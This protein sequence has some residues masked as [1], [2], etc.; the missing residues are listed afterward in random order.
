MAQT[1]FHV[2]VTSALAQA[3]D[4]LNAECSLEDK[5]TRLSALMHLEEMILYQDKSQVTAE[6]SVFLPRLAALPVD[7]SNSSDIM[8]KTFLWQ[9]VTH[10]V[11]LNELLKLSEELFLS[12]ISM[13][14]EMAFNKNTPWLFREGLLPCLL[15]MEPHYPGILVV[16]LPRLFRVIVSEKS[17][18]IQ[19]YVQLFGTILN[20]SFSLSYDIV[21]DDLKQEIAAYQK[22]MNSIETGPYKPSFKYVVT[23][24]ILR[25]KQSKVAPVCQ[26]FGYSQLLKEKIRL[27]SPVANVFIRQQLQGIALGS[28]GL[29]NNILYLFTYCQAVPDKVDAI[30]CL[31]NSDF[32]SPSFKHV[33]LSWYTSRIMKNLDTQGVSLAAIRSPFC[34]ST[35]VAFKQ[36]SCSVLDSAILSSFKTFGI[37]NYDS[38]CAILRSI[39]LKNDTYHSQYCELFISQLFRCN[40]RSNSVNTIVCEALDAFNDQLLV[41]TFAEQLDTF[42]LST[43]SKKRQRTEK[44]LG[45][46]LPIFSK[47]TLRRL[48][49]N[50]LFLWE[51][52][53]IITGEEKQRKQ[54]TEE[55]IRNF[56]FFLC[57]FICMVPSFV[58][59]NELTSVNNGKII[60]NI[61]EIETEIGSMA[62][63]LIQYCDKFSATPCMNQ[64]LIV[65]IYKPL[66]PLELNWDLTM[67][68]IFNKTSFPVRLSAPITG[69]DAFLSVFESKTNGYDEM[70][71]ELRFSQDSVVFN[72]YCFGLSLELFALSPIAGIDKKIIGQHLVP[73]EAADIRTVSFS[74]IPDKTPLGKQPVIEKIIC[75]VS[76]STGNSHMYAA[77]MEPISLKLTDVLL[78]LKIEGDYSLGDLFVSTLSEQVGKNDGWLESVMKTLATPEKL[79]VSSLR[80]F[81]LLKSK[82]LI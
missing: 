50:K 2:Q 54:F 20:H 11:I 3:Q 49:F 77:W 46:F 51:F 25:S 21:L 23:H 45:D 65:P 30:Q 72:C 5:F 35:D 64:L 36:L 15:E 78:P 75:R 62:V 42:C 4:I 73:V 19:G 41:D 55:K 1:H 68:P 81:I 57:S 18:A 14:V 17:P 40:I 32:L 31:V 27:C 24:R 37:V 29:S 82:L 56:L 66:T 43:T 60:N 63:K 59:D 44:L 69:L 47:L 53:D 10:V 34:N 39:M 58:K 76:F 79:A 12:F 52:C 16:S 67:I 28:F 33:L 70:N 7:K 8:L 9:L 22:G 13:M 6:L 61:N 48:N 71:F 80:H 26:D 38:L 74:I